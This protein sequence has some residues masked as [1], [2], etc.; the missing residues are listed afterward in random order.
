MP[1]RFITIQG[2]PE[3]NEEVVSEMLEVRHDQG[4]LDDETYEDGM[5]RVALPQDGP[6][7]GAAFVKFLI[8]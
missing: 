4:I 5:R 3:Y 8:E 6:V 7:V 1:K 2:H